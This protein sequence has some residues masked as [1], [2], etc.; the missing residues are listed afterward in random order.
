[1][2][3]RGELLVRDPRLCS[4]ELIAF[5]SRWEGRR[6]KPY[7]DVAGLWTVGVGHLLGRATP[8]QW[9]YTE[10]EVDEL[11][12]RDLERIGR[13]VERLCGPLAQHRFFSL[14]SFAF[15][16][17]LGSLQRSVLRQRVLRGAANAGDA[18][19]M[20]NKAGGRII[21]GLTLRRHAERDLYCGRT[22]PQYDS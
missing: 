4:P 15:N 8:T 7:Q 9:L 14:V 6:L 13:G 22:Q 12:S 11:L 16:V 5:L 10:A 20:W 3:Q 1:M 18:F 19:L 21:H 2:G 17:G